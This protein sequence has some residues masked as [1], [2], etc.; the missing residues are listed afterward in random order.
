MQN[1]KLIAVVFVASTVISSSAKAQTSLKFIDGI[2]MKPA[3]IEY[4]TSMPKAQVTHIPAAKK[5]MAKAN[6][7]AKTSIE[8]SNKLQFK[9]AQLL[10]INVENLTNLS[11]LSLIDDWWKTRYRYGGTTKKGID[12]SALTGLL[13]RSAYD[14][15]VPRTARMQYAD[16]EKVSREN[17]KEGDL[18]FFNTTG[19][20]SHVGL[21]LA[22]DHFVH[23]SSSSGVTISSLN[24]AYFSARFLGGGRVKETK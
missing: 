8:A 4:A 12:C 23:A 24:E 17:L 22:N 7:A 19:G 11:L 10:D 6:A 20:V 18:V 9:Y 16:C 13:L 5:A 2:E 21:Y 14:V 15:D 3:V 1:L